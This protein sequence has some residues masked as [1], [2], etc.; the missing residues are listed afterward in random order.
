MSDKN[1]E[2]ISIVLAG[3]PNSGKT[4]IFNNITGS[5][6]HVGNYPGV[7]VE[8]KEGEATYNGTKL[9]CIDLPGTYSLTARSLDEVVARN[10]I[11]NEHPDLIVN[12]LDASNLE[13]NLYLTAQLMELG[14]P[15]VLVLNMID[16]AEEMGIQIDAEKLSAQFNAPVVVANGRNN[17]GTTEILIAI[18][19]ASKT[20][21]IPTGSINFGTELEN[22]IAELLP[23]VEAN[24]RITYAKRWVA[25]KLIEGDTDI[26]EKISAVPGGSK[27]VEKAIA[28][29]GTTDLD[30]IESSFQEARHHFAI[31][32]FNNTVT[33]THKFA[34]SKS[35]KIDALLTHRFLGLPIFAA[36]MWLLFNFVITIGAYPQDW[37]EQG[38]GLLSD[39]VRIV[40]PNGQLQS[41]LV[42]GVIG[43]VG[44]VLSFLPLIVLLFLGIAF[45]EDTGYM[46]RAA[47]LMDRIMRGFG[48]H[49]KS[50]IPLL[51]GFGCS[52]PAIMGSRI[53]DNP[54]DRMVTILVTPFMSCSAKLPV[55]TLLAAAFW[56]PE[57]GGTVLFCV[58]FASIIL[59]C[60]MGIIF[61][62][63]LFAGETDPFVMEM[64]P[65]HAPTM[66]AVFMH[67]WERAVLYVKKAGTFILAA[68]ILV[69]FL[70]SYP[71]NVEYSQ[72][73]DGA[74]DQIT[75]IFDQ[76]SDQIMMAMGAISNEDK[77]KVTALVEKITATAEKHKAE[78]ADETVV[79]AE[80]EETNAEG[81]NSLPSENPTADAIAA[82]DEPLDTAAFI[83]D[84]N[85]MHI[86]TAFDSIKS[87]DAKQ[88]NVAWTIY[89]NEQVRDELIKVVDEHQRSEKVSQSYAAQFGKAIEPIIE[90]LGF[91]WR[92]GVGLI[93]AMAA[94][95]VLISTLGTI[96]SIEADEDN[97]GSLQQLLQQDPN[98]SPLV[99]VALMAFVLVYPPCLS[100]LAVIKRET[101]S[102]K[103]LAFVFCYENVFAYGVALLIFQ[104]GSAMGF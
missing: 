31:E 36:V 39:W 97:N 28:I 18:A 6:Q 104:I 40:V 8:K 14:R 10:V 21:N 13:R 19:E 86:P 71:E 5:K 44:A 27:I 72:D 67:M 46:A 66:K 22:K 17:V 70:V 4:T 7:T 75:Q 69:W 3:N 54:R 52:V 78:I 49:G 81:E 88:F 9:L 89:Q 12:V 29:R 100:A 73:F 76:K 11:I 30:E 74:R 63:T 64:P 26:V 53:L 16:I 23:L 61:R 32:V 34:S 95:E 20:A 98:F 57:Q 80:S 42:D 94:K 15:M 96:Y 55:Y 25:A 79:Q 50:F 101:N 2:R 45:L 1:I 92:I 62:K 33:E 51:L 37:L 60:I 84:T 65:Y 93:A 68:S 48:L 38:F 102:W 41:L 58:Y 59:A 43:G 85:A 35:D 83:K 56:P 91:N 24:E 87:Q 103:W 77:E 82:A 47:F 99:A 90:P